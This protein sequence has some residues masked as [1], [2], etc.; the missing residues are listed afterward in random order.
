MDLIANFLLCA[1]A[2]S[3]VIYCHLLSR[4][5]RQFQDLDSGVG[6]AIAQLSKQVDSLNATLRDARQTASQA[7]STAAEQTQR[8]EDAAHR[9]ELLLASMHDIDLTPPDTGARQ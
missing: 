9:L 4:R 6:L 5:L 3:A 7:K 2:I 8:A 1:G